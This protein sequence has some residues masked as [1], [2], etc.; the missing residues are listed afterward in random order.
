MNSKQNRISAIAQII[1]D[2]IVRSQQDIISKLNERGMDITQAS[3]SRYLKEIQASR[4][5]DGSGGYVYKLPDNQNSKSHNTIAGEVV[6]LEFVGQ[7]M[8]VVRTGGG[9]ANA[10]SAIIDSRNFPQ[11][12]GTVSGDDTIIIVIRDGYSR[13]QIKHTLINE[14]PNMKDKFVNE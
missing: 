5:P 4:I 9:Y 6:S 8:I 2:E 7:S 13:K 12:A 1:N 14:F 11:F 10:V 3:L